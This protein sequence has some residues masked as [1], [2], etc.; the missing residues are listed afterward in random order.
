MPGDFLELHLLFNH[1]VKLLSFSKTQCNKNSCKLQGCKIQVFRASEF[2]STI[3]V[4]KARPPAI[5]L[6]CLL[7]GKLVDWCNG[8]DYG[9]KSKNVTEAWQCERLCVLQ[10]MQMHLHCDCSS[11]AINWNGLQKCGPN[12]PCNKTIRSMYHG[13]SMGE[14]ISSWG[15]AII[16]SPQRS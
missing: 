16:G 3:P 5:L 14:V 6:L 13:L 15:Y 1:H 7:Q 2:T 10:L 8:I 4:T 9:L 12:G 11:D